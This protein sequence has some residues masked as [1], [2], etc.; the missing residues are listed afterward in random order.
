[1][2]VPM[3]VFSSST[4]ALVSPQATYDFIISKKSPTAYDQW[5]VV[6]GTAHVDVALGK[7]VPTAVFPQIG[8]W[9]K[10]VNTLSSNPPNTYTPAARIDE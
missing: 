4:G 8:N 7:R 3:I 10:S 9:L 1:M 6:G 5:Y 2:T